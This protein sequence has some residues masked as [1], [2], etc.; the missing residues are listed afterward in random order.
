METAGRVPA[1][2]LPTGLQHLGTSDSDDDANPFWEGAEFQ[3]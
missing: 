3:D 1:F 2:S